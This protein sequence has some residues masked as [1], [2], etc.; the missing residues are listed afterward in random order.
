MKEKGKF[1]VVVTDD[2]EQVKEL[3]DALGIAP[4]QE[5]LDA[6]AERAA[7]EEKESEA[8][9]NPLCPCCCFKG[10]DPDK[11]RGAVE[12]VMKLLTHDQLVEAST[13]LFGIA[14]GA[15]MAMPSPAD[16][17]VGKSLAALTKILRKANP[18]FAFATQPINAEREGAAKH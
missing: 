11:K 16:H 13:I 3:F 2:P 6:M 10:T 18:E 5:L 14:A 9:G 15:Y 12:A 1:K 4:P 7:S 17:E 8:C